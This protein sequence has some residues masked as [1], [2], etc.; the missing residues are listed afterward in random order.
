MF[1]YNLEADPSFGV[2]VMDR[3]LGVGP[4]DGIPILGAVLLDKS[5]WGDVPVGAPWRRSHT[6]LGQLTGEHP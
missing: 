5:G 6:H 3:M 4:K 2:M 1:A